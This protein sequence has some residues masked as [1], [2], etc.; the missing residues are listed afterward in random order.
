MKGRK[1]RFLHSHECMIDSFEC[2]IGSNDRR[3][4]SNEPRIDSIDRGIWWN[5]AIVVS[6]DLSPRVPV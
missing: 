2:R 6:D 1:S 4:G 5:E 3:I